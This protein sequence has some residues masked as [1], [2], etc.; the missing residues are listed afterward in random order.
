MD[1]HLSREGRNGRYEGRHAE[2]R[3]WRK[4]RFLRRRSAPHVL[5]GPIGDAGDRLLGEVLRAWLQVGDGVRHDVK[6]LTGW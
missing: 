3:H 5:H 6:V 4:G 1:R 2:R